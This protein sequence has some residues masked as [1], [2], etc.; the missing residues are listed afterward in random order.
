MAPPGSST[1]AALGV[2]ALALSVVA[3]PAEAPVPPM[4]P[5]RFDGMR[6][7]ADH[8]RIWI[9]PARGA[10]LR[11]RVKG[12]EVAEV[13]R[14]AGRSVP[15]LALTSVATGDDRFCREA[16]TQALGPPA[17]PGTKDEAQKRNSI[18]TPLFQMALAYDWCHA[19][20]DGEET[21]RFRAAMVPQMRKEMA[22]GR[23]W[24]SFHNSGHSHAFP[25]TAAA[26][27]LHGDDPVAEEALAFL[28]P[29]LEDMIKTFDLVFPD[30][31]WGEGLDYD[32]HSSHPAL[33]TFLAIRSATGIDVLANSPHFRN[34]ARYIFYATKPNGLMFPG[35]DNDWPYLGGWERSA[36]LMLAAQYRDPHAQYFLNHCPIERFALEEQDR[37]ADLLWYDPALAEAPLDEL[38]L[39][40][41]FRDKGLVLARTGWAWDGPSAPDTWLAFS[42]GDY[43]GDHDH[44]DVN[45]FQIYRKGEL[46]IDSGRYDDDWDFFDQPEKIK[47]SQFFNYYQRTIAHNTLLVDDPGEVFERGILN[48]GG[49]RHILWKGPYRDVP[50][51]Y[52]Q[53]TFPSDEGRGTSDWATNPGRWERGDITAYQATRD[54]VYVRGDG[55]KAYS[56]R[57]LSSFVRELLFLSP[58]L[59]VVFDRV[60]STRADFKK[61]WLL[62]TVDEPQ[63]A[64]D[65]SWFE[66]TEGKGRLVGIP[67]WPRPARLRKIGGPGQEFL[68]AGTRYRAGLESTLNPAALH[69]GENPGAWRIE[70]SPATPQTEDYFLNVMLLTDKG[71]TEKPR[72]EAVA[73]DARSISFR[74]RDDQG[75]EANL[76]FAKGPQPSLALKLSRAGRVLHEGRMPDMV[77]P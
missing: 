34:T 67:L 54:F 5:T 55:T 59:V 61:T 73:S 21:A 44:Y 17:T 3:G 53:G 75:T 9:D 23:T 65:G 63:V 12:Q 42:N 24:R 13:A 45:S 33:R 57:K 10:W 14:R 7:R 35:D 50:E 76:R 26:L 6:V 22:Q 27:A 48:D 70:E 49:Q 41:I 47:Q 16:I 62:H 68:V 31:A 15:G 71:S 46:A 25:L 60:V 36:L 51:D 20:L 56:A 74:V 30:G 37:W 69:Y 72:I 19:S 40:R 8:P 18:Q 66:V 43:Y 64:A 38:P 29:E 77:T 28:K 1:R 11:E 32:R 52:D 4:K 39:S 58:R 2:S